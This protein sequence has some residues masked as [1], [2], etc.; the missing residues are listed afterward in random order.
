[1]NADTAV[2][3]PAT[4]PFRDALMARDWDAVREALNPDVVLNSPILTTPFV[5]R[6]AVVE[7]FEVIRETLE[8]IQFTVDMADGDVRFMSWRTHIG[9]VQMEGAEIMRLDKDGRIK[10]FTVFFRPLVGVTTLASALGKGLAGR[11]SPA[12]GRVAA[13]ASRPM[14]VLSRVADRVAPKLVK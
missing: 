10:E 8:D 1:M 4:H 13:V 9:D 14:V 5:G 12:R 2:A 3:P 7:L 6:E 11:R